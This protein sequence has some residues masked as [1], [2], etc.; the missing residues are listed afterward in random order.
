MSAER[1]LPSRQLLKFQDLT[2]WK[3]IF[4]F[5]E[6]NPMI[7][8]Y[9]FSICW[10]LKIQI[11]GP[12]L[13]WMVQLEVHSPIN[14]LIKRRETETTLTSFSSSAPTSPEGDPGNEVEITRGTW[15]YRKH[16]G[17]LGNCIF[18]F[19]NKNIARRE[20]SSKCFSTWLLPL[21]KQVF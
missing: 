18:K 14:K 4:A 15:D 6:T 2:I 20:S 12:S 3:Y 7:I 21:Y 8:L 5:D 13:A 16:S 10:D 1:E 9:F 17:I 11:L 19:G